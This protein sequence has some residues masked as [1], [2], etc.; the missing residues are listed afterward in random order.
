[1]QSSRVMA[2]VLAALVAM[3]ASF[4]GHLVRTGNDALAL[5]LVPATLIV[6]LLSAAIMRE[7]DRS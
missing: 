7:R 3:P 2:G 4:A 6:I 1:M 5:K